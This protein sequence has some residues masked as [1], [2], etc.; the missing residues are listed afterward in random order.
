V[1]KK[2]IN[3]D[4]LLAPRG[5]THIV[6]IAG[7]ANLVFISG[8]VA[9][10]KQGKLVGPGD[11]KTQIRQAANNLK[12]ALAAAGATA[13]D[14]VKT[15]TYIVNYKQSDYSAMREAR[16]ELFGDGEP[17]ASTLVGVTSLAVEGLMVEMEAIAAVK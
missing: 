12:A 13:A 14:I 9:V 6:T 17:P 7:P 3:P 2:Y 16:A 1:E 10:D 4:T 8:Q 11:L 15:N 5:Y